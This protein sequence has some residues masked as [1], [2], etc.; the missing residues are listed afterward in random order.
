[1]IRT[2]KCW[3]TSADL[4]EANNAPTPA[5]H[6][7]QARH[8]NSARPATPKRSRGHSRRPG[9]AEASLRPELACNSLHASRDSQT[10]SG[11]EACEYLEATR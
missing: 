7:T 10:S 9:A 2:S 6:S 4:P 8:V 11:N 3:K 5:T 1:M